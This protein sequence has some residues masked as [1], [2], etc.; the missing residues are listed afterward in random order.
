[1]TKRTYFECDN[2]QCDTKILIDST[3]D[4]CENNEYNISIKCC[5]YCKNEY[6]ANCAHM[7]VNSGLECNC[8]ICD[9]EYC[10]DRHVDNCITLRRIFEEKYPDIN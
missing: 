2:H 8:D 7:I 9:D 1:M 3:R 4:Y 5:D 10:K 6:C